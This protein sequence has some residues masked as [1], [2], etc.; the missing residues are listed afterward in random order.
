MQLKPRKTHKIC[1][2][3]IRGLSETKKI[4]KKLSTIFFLLVSRFYYFKSLKLIFLLFILN[5]II[6][7]KK[8]D[9][10]NKKES[11][12]MRDF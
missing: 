6:D 4:F 5:F 2:K 10:Q 9:W 1:E 3:I 7:L 12:L 11:C 8:I